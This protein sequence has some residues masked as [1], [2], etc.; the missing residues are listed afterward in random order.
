MQIRIL[1]TNDVCNYPEFI[2]EAIDLLPEAPHTSDSWA[3][4]KNEQGR[5]VAWFMVHKCLCEL[6]ETPYEHVA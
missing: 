6:I 5:L 1:S 4:A 3:F 2:G